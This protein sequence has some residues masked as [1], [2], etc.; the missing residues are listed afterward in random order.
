MKKSFYSLVLLLLLL[1]SLSQGQ[2]LSVATD[3]ARSIAS[4]DSVSGET[5]T[6]L[7]LSRPSESLM[8]Y[9]AEK[10]TFTPS[11]DQRISFRQEV[12]EKK[13]SKVVMFLV[14]EAVVGLVS[15]IGFAKN[16][17]YWSAAGL[18]V[19]SLA[20]FNGGKAPENDETGWATFGMMN[21]LAAHH[22][23]VKPTSGAPVFWRNFIGVNAVLLTSHVMD[24]VI[25]RK[26]A[27]APTNFQD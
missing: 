15:S 5:T 7:R 26:K 4:A 6:I 16:G 8:A 23:F 9:G 3:S 24:K 21:A 2:R 25:S 20:A 18:H 10:G 12:K 13:E 14:G 11:F 27:K 19:M 22:Y 17:A 1:P